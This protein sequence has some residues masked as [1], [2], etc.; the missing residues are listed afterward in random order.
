MDVAVVIR[1]AIPA[2]ER[3]LAESGSTPPTSANVWIT[4][5][6]RGHVTEAHLS[7]DAGLGIDR[8]LLAA[9]RTVQFHAPTN[10]ERTWGIPISAP[11]Q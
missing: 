1:P 2:L 4:L 3:C 11:P 9:A 8:C 6:D 10:G 5:D 7:V